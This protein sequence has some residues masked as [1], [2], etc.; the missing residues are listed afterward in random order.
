MCRIFSDC[1]QR[2]TSVGPPIA[3]SL[4]GFSVVHLC[5]WVGLRILSW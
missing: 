4:V 3:G 2:V 5:G 1:R